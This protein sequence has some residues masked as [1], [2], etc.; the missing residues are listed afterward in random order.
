MSPS[1]PRNKRLL[2][3]EN[4]YNLRTTHTSRSE[5]Y[6]MEHTSPDDY[7]EKV[8]DTKTTNDDDKYK[9]DTS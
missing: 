9:G 7:I 2:N 5:K 3:E 1:I 6:D 8:K 4:G